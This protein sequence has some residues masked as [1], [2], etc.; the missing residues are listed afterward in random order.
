MTESQPSSDIAVERRNEEFTMSGPPSGSFDAKKQAENQTDLLLDIAMTT[1]FAS[2]LDGTPIT[3]AHALFSFIGV[4]V[5]IWWA[6]AGQVLYHARFREGDWLHIILYFICQ[7]AVFMAFTVFTGNFDIEEGL[8]TTTKS[9][10]IED[11]LEGARSNQGWTPISDMSQR[12]HDERVSVRSMRGIAMTMALSRVMILVEYL[13]AT[14]RLFFS[15]PV[16]D[17]WHTNHEKGST[18]QPR[19]YAD[20]SSPEP[21]NSSLQIIPSVAKIDFGWRLRHFPQYELLYYHCGAVFLSFVS[22]L[23]SFLLIGSNP[24]RGDQIARI[25]LWYSPIILEIAAHYMVAARVKAGNWEYNG[26][27]VHLRRSVIFTIILGA[28]LDRMTDN[29]HYMVGTLSFDTHR[30]FIIFC[31]GLNIIFLFTLHYTNISTH[32][33]DGSNTFPIRRRILTSFF[34]NFIYLCALVVTL[35]GMIAVLQMGDIGDVMGTAFDFVRESEHHLN[36]TQPMKPLT[37]ELYNATTVKKLSKAGYNLTVLLQPINKAI[38]TPDDAA[39]PFR[40]VLLT[41]MDIVASGLR[42][43]N[44]IVQDNSVSS[45]GI[46]AFL[47]NAHRGSMNTSLGDINKPHFIDIATLAL[48][49]NTYS[50]WW[51]TAAGGTVLVLLAVMELL[52]HWGTIKTLPV[53]QSAQAENKPMSKAQ[54]IAFQIGGKLTAGVALICLTALADRGDALQLNTNYNFV[55]NRMWRLAL[56]SWLL[57][58]YVLALFVLQCYEYVRINDVLPRYAPNE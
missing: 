57:P 13:C 44:L 34:L 18:C 3:D 33:E 5:L 15:D 55:G 49:G 22:Y 43:L 50:A 32:P 37:T 2:L 58:I 52:D 35:Q 19:A 6:W 47:A 20:S 46:R 51:F 4:F 40:L 7:L 48:T 45:N 1:A 9:D 8:A 23:A 12:L 29:F 42:G 25:C 39:Y 26:Y 10:S 11:A 56:Q 14:R 28:G 38:P 24:S 17:N 21:I 30:I 31:A 16:V 36:S 27:A 53:S 54:G 41:G